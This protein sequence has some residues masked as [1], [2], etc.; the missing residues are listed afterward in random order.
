MTF[1]VLS[2]AALSTSGN[3]CPFLCLKRYLKSMLG[4]HPPSA[5]PGKPWCQITVILD[6]DLGP[7]VRFSCRLALLP[8][9]PAGGSV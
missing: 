8:E 3:V 6:R 4:L 1:R 9:N 5:L 2:R 7:E